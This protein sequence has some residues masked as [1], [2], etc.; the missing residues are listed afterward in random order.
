MIGLRIS[1]TLAEIML[2]R[3]EEDHLFWSVAMLAVSLL[4]YIGGSQL[5]L[6]RKLKRYDYS[7]LPQFSKYDVE[8]GCLLDVKEGDSIEFTVEAPLTYAH[9]VYEYQRTLWTKIQ[10][11]LVRELPPYQYTTRWAKILIVFPKVRNVQWIRKTMRPTVDPD[12]TVDYGDIDYF[13]AEGEKSHL[14]GDWGEIEI[15]SGPV[16]VREVCVLDPEW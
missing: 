5:R 14:I 8:N 9:P 12:G 7:K 4:I 6:G 16:E 11:A 2:D 15:I 3:W 10:D 13:T 1:R